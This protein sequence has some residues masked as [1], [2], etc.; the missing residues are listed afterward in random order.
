MSKKMR[1]GRIPKKITL[2][3]AAKTLLEEASQR[4]SIPEGTVVEQALQALF[5]DP[6]LKSFEDRK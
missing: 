2:S 5:G 1:L 4:L 6:G 3:P